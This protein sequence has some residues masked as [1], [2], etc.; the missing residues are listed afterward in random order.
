MTRI[1]NKMIPPGMRIIGCFF[2]AMII[3]LCFCAIIIPSISFPSV[4]YLCIMIIPCALFALTL[5]FTFDAG[6]LTIK[7][8][9]FEKKIPIYSIMEINY[10]FCGIFSLG[11]YRGMLNEKYEIPLLFLCSKKRSMKEMN[12][13]ID[14]LAQNKYHVTLNI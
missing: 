1:E 3:F 2:M 13:F 4:F 14:F 12:K 9:F 5:F 10:G 7:C 8:C 11:V 6:N